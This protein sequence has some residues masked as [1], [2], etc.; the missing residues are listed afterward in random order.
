MERWLN[1][2]TRKTTGKSSCT[3]PSGPVAAFSITLIPSYNMHV[4]S[5]KMTHAFYTV[6]ACKT[7]HSALRNLKGHTN[8][9]N[10]SYIGLCAQHIIINYKLYMRQLRV[11]NQMLFTFQLK[12]LLS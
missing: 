6:H 1:L 4:H 10:N 3:L 5:N 12:L 11:E 9:P 8:I 7:C 2:G